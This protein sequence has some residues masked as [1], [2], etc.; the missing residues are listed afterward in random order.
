[1]KGRRDRKRSN[2]TSIYW[3]ISRK[4][5]DAGNLK[6]KHRFAPCGEFALEEDLD[7]S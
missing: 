5:E 2:K 3:M 1:M 7:L 4:V 6:R